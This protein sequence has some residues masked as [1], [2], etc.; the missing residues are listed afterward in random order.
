MPE[1]KVI[2]LVMDQMS[3]VQIQQPDLEFII[4]VCG[5]MII[6]GPLRFTIDHQGHTI[7]DEYQV[8]II[9]PNNY[10]DSPPKVRET[11]NTIPE[12]FHKFHKTGCLCLGAPV[13]VRRVFSRHKSLFGFVNTQ[14]IP[15]L[16]SY[17]YF[18]DYGILPYGD[19]AHGSSGLLNYYKALFQVDII[20]T[21]NFLK[22]LA[23]DIV[24]PLMECP[25]GNGKVLR[26]CH[27]PILFELQSFYSPQ[28]F[29]FELRDII[30]L[31]RQ[32]GIRIPERIVMPRRLWKRRE[33]RARKASRHR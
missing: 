1:E 16:F 7:E 21:M 11:G 8:E 33:K 9:I 26:D 30:A 2:R 31:V 5:E 18:R 29:D 28:E 10:P 4:S 27:G 17:S 6:H 13:E 25:C 15:Y 20:R 23:D 19:L 3:E 32:K 24:P 12:G 14:V 22:L